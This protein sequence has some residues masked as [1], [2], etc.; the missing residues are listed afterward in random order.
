MPESSRFSR[1]PEPY[2]LEHCRAHPADRNPSADVQGE[3]TMTSTTIEQTSKAMTD[4]AGKSAAAAEHILKSGA[5]TMNRAAEKTEENLA[6]TTHAINKSGHIAMSGL[7]ELA[8]AY[9]SLANR[10]AAQF[11]SSMQAFASVKT[12]AEFIA[13]QQKLIRESLDAAVGDFRNIAK[14]TAAVFTASFEPL[15]KQIETVQAS[16]TK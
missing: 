7:Q 2:Q 3:S 16:A 15:Q 4:G 12:P 8:K 11:A 1:F 10:N 13:L 6:A 14:L 9:E 5:S